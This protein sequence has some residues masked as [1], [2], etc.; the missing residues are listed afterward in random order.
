M[1]NQKITIEQLN[2]YSEGTLV[3]HLGIVFTEIGPDYIKA[4][5]PVGEHTRQPQGVLHGGASASLAETLGSSGS[6]CLL[7]LERHYPVGV[8][9]N[10]NHLRPVTSGYVYG[11]ATWLHLGR[12][13]HVW[14]IKIVD[15]AGKLVCASRLTLMIVDA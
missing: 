4:K 7:D 8:E 15:E 13:T 2:A 10:A 1:I 9:L 5:M 3:S 12:R 14:D 6:A 11:T